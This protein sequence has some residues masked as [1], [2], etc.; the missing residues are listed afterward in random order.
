MDPHRL[1]FSTQTS[2]RRRPPT[3]SPAKRVCVGEE[4]RWSERALPDPGEAR[5]TKSATTKGPVARREFRHPLRFPR[6]GNFTHPNRCASPVTGVWG[7]FPRVGWATMDTLVS[8]GAVPSGVLVTLPPR[9]KSLAALGRRNSPKSERKV[10]E[11]P[12]C[13]ELK[14]SI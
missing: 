2:R 7:R 9:A 6:A 1:K 10:K 13:A 5:D 3:Q 8:I 4:E 14:K 11:R 12:I